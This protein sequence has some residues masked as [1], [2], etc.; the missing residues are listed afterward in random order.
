MTATATDKRSHDG[1]KRR[2]LVL[3]LTYGEPEE[4]EFGP[5][6]EY[7]HSI[8]DRLTRRVAPIPKFVT[9]LIAARRARIRAANFREKN[10]NSPLEKI[11][12]AQARVLKELLEEMEPGTDFDV[13][14]LREFRPPLLP[15]ILP[16]LESNPP[17]DILV[18]PLYVAESDFTTGISRTDFETYYRRAHGRTPLPAPRYVVGFGFDERFADAMA[19]FIMSYCR[20]NGWDEEKL[21]ESALILGAHG[22]VVTLP[23]GMNSGAQETGN[24]FRLVRKRLRDKFAWMR[25][26]WLNHTLGG[27]WTCPSAEQAAQEAHDL[28]LRKVVYFPFGFIG[29]NGE[30]MLEGR[31]QLAVVEWDEMLYLPCPNEDRRVLGVMAR[32]ALERLEQPPEDWKTIGRGNPE[33]E[34]PEMP[35]GRGTPGFLKFNGPA[36]A[37]FACAFWSLVGVFLVSRG[38]LVGSQIASPLILALVAFFSVLI[39]WGKGQSILAPLALK[40][41]KRLRSIP[42]PSPMYRMFSKASWIVIAFFVCL[43]ISLRFVPMPMGLRA[44]ILLGVGGAMLVGAAGYVLNFAMATPIKAKLPTKKKPRHEI[45][46]A[47]RA[48]K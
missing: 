14:V 27:M 15:E 38:L 19:D 3:C 44:T 24:L 4:N 26:G 2:V 31:Q 46:G 23:A 45:A 11:S 21:K 9:P 20:E 8:L 7:S 47:V 25:I 16:T 5:Q 17:D 35:A 12:E 42:Q 39:A 32:M 48:V 41:L 6:Y 29:D 30:S 33:L 43:G 34:R 18:F 37:A 40:N 1:K 28:G 10:W 13:R 22:T 36:L